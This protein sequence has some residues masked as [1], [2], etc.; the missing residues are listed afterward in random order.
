ME[1]FS[2]K[3]EA[4]KEDWK[5][6]QQEMSESVKGQIKES[7][8]AKLWNMFG[9]IR[10]ELGEAKSQFKKDIAEAKAQNLK[11]LEDTFLAPPDPATDKKDSNSKGSD[12]RTI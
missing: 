1:E 11:S 5:K 4:Q 8:P 7:E 12:D 2:A 3:M 10:K 6:S 9:E